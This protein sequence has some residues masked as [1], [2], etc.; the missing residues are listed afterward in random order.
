MRKL[1]MILILGFSLIFSPLA[2]AQC[3]DTA[4][5]TVSATLTRTPPGPGP[6]P[7][8]GGAIVGIAGGGVA[9]G[10]S[11][12]AFAPLLLAGLSP[13]SLLFAA[14]PIC[15][16][17]C[18]QNLL[19][20]AIMN[21][22]CSSDYASAA[23]KM[24]LNPNAYLVQNNS[25]LINGTYDMHALTLPI[26]VQNVN[27]VKIDV[28]VTS[29]QFN[30]FNQEP[31]LVFGL[32][33]DINQCN[34][35]KK[36]QTQQFLHHYLMSKYEI[37]LKITSLNPACGIQKLSGIIDMSKVQN[38]KCPMQVVIRYTEGGFKKGQKLQNPKTMVYAYVAEFQ[39]LR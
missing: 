15:C 30:T 19:Q 21:H 27:K 39:K 28:T 11:A 13:N 17:P 35:S 2:I 24:S 10:A 33:K 6:T 38:P 18:V 4:S 32:Y 7:I 36:F 12:F 20:A 26:E 23:A 31:E 25:E 14:A 5:Q 8:P 22:F 16:V 3:I 1:F 34:L 9:A 37:P 29:Q